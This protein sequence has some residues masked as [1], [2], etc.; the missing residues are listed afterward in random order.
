MNPEFD[1]NLVSVIIPT[2]NR[3]SLL[4]ETLDSV[5]RQS[6]RPLE[7]IVVDDGSSD[8]TR[9]MMERWIGEH[10]SGAGLRI[11]F[12]RQPNSGAPAARNLGLI[13]SRGEF[14]QFLDSDDLLAERKVELCVA[15]LSEDARAQLAYG[16]TQAFGEE[17]GIDYP[18]LATNDPLEVLEA[19]CVRS[20]W[21]IMG[22]VYRRELCVQAGPWLENLSCWQD[23]EY[24]LRILARSPA[25]CFVPE[26]MSF[27]RLGH[28]MNIGANWSRDERDLHSIWRGA[29]AAAQAIDEGCGFTP[30]MRERLARQF[31]NVG[32]LL[33][34]LGHVES[35]RS[36]LKRAEEVAQGSPYARTVARLRLLTTLAGF[37]LTNRGLA[38]RA[39][40][41]GQA[42]RTAA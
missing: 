31:V 24:A 34:Q 41:R 1:R 9:E 29:E 37:R 7:V 13:E 21:T 30:L 28:G 35:G 27:Y 8:D 17:A 16:A 39:R 12:L 20:V 18:G 3:S 15:A 19:A 11:S 6:Y 2:Y 40:L 26:A 14:I 36:A 32:R 10:S 42:P 23:R 25:L 4:A 38:L 33:G 5:V 22:P